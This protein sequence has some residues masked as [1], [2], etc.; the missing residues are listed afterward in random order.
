MKLADRVGHFSESVI[1]EMTRLADRHGAI[2]LGQG[3]PDFEAPQERQG[4][5]LPG[6]PGRLQP[7]R[8][9]LG[10]PAAAR[11]DR[12]Q[13][14]RAFNGIP[15]DPDRNVTVCCGATECMMATMLALVDPGDEVVIFQ[16][17]YENYGPDAMHQR[18]Q[19]R[20]GPAA[21][22]ALDVRPGR[23]ARALFARGPRRSSS[24]RRTT[25]PGTSSPARNCRSSPSCASEFDAFALTDEI[26]EYIIYTDRPHVSIASLPGM[27]RAD[28]DD[29]RAVED[30]QR[31]RLAARVLHRPGGGHATASARR[32]TS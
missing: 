16:P 7:V 23:T 21:P 5:R 26:Y 11:G 32:T 17:F 25:R 4:R 8:D 9:H 19:A 12:R 13:G 2:N 24:T 10:R 22:A 20:L 15:C 6:H 27:A 28:G 1:R 18:G 14:A 29:Q 3:M 30:V 31:H